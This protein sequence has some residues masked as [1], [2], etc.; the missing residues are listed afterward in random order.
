MID[1]V[2]NRT[3]MVATLGPACSERS[4]LVEMIKAGVDVCR[5]NASH[6]DHAYLQQMID[7]V[8]SLN[9]EEG[10]FVSTLLDLQGPKIRV[11]ALAEPFPI[12]AGME[13][14]FNTQ[15]KERVGDTLPMQLETFARDVKAGDL[16]L[17]EDGKVELI[18]LE[19][20]GSHEVRLRVK[21]GTSIGS[22][23][24]VNLPFT[25]LS[26]PSMTPKD[27]ADLELGMRNNV[28][29]IALSFVRRAQDVLELKETLRLNNCKAKVC[30][31]IE[32]PEALQN[33][34]EII[35]AADAIMVARGDLGVE[36]PI[37]EVPF[38]QKKIVRKCNMAGRP[39]IVATQMMESMIENI[40]PTRAEATDVANAVLDGADAVMVSGETSVGKHPVEVIRTMQRLIAKA[41]QEDAVYNRRF[42]VD[43]ESTT[44][45]SDAICYSAC[46]MAKGINAKAIV[47]MT[48]SGYTA[49]QLS[50]H[51]P[52]VSIFIFTDNE[53]LLSTLSLVWGVRTLYYDRF[54]GTNE[55]IN[56][57]IGILQQM[58]HVQPGDVVVNTASMP[59]QSRGRTNML[60]ITV[61][62]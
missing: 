50:R 39:V 33:I 13:V 52:Q 12:H 4:V 44:F 45:Y 14:V 46:K 53:Q 59:L 3:K 51:R 29:W 32:K 40:R 60:K 7:L 34:D 19:T 57:V 11:G 21:H 48:R 49:F 42:G 18:V 22:K 56:D 17:V 31:K 24:G 9:R 30:A 61:V 37:E 26:I 20:D 62:E 27:K 25:S 43:R 1:S 28:D 16:I 35:N 5:L 38:W 15:I 8:R 2:Y 6:G 23:K 36:I 54:V 47:S 10:V 58:G 55:S 41:E